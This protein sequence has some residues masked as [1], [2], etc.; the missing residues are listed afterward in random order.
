MLKYNATQW[1]LEAFTRIPDPKPLSL[2]SRLL[3]NAFKYNNT[4]VAKYLMIGTSTS[5]TKLDAISSIIQHG[6]TE[7]FCI[8][9]NVSG[10]ATAFI[11]PA[12]LLLPCIN[13]GNVDFV[14]LLLK[15]NCF[16][17]LQENVV[18]QETLELTSPR[19]I[20][21]DMLKMLHEEYNILYP[22]KNNVVWSE[23]LEY[24]IRHNL[25]DCVKYI[26]SNM[27]EFVDKRYLEGLLGFIVKHTNN[28]NVE[29]FESLC[30]TV[31]GPR[32]LLNHLYLL[33]FTQTSIHRGHFNIIKHL[34]T[35]LQHPSVRDINTSQSMTLICEYLGVPVPSPNSS[36][37]SNDVVATLTKGAIK[38]G[39]EAILAED[40]DLTVALLNEVE[41]IDADVWHKMS[42]K[43]GMFIT[44]PSH[45][46]LSPFNIVSLDGLL[47]SF[48]MPGC[49][50]TQDIILRFIDNCPST[51]YVGQHHS[52]DEE[53]INDNDE[54]IESL[55]LAAA[56]SQVVVRRMHS[57]FN[58][59]FTTDSLRDA[60]IS[61]DKETLS[62]IFD[63]VDEDALERWSSQI[64]DVLSALHQLL[65]TGT[66]EMIT[67]VLC[68]MKDIQYDGDVIISTLAS[69]HLEVVKFVFGMLSFEEIQANIELI[70][71]QIY[72]MDN[73]DA[74][75]WFGELFNGAGQTL[76]KATLR[77][78][79]MAT[80]GNAYRL[81]EL[82]FQSPDFNNMSKVLR[83]RT[84]NAIMYS[85]QSI[86]NTRIINH[87]Q[88]LIKLIQSN[89]KRDRDQHDVKLDVNVQASERLETA[90]HRVFMD[91]KMS[92]K[93]MDNVAVV[94]QSLGITSCVKGSRLLSMN[95]LEEYIKYGASQWFHQSYQVLDNI[96]PMHPNTHLLELAMLYPNTSILDTL[97]ADPRMVFMPSVDFLE[98][99]IDYHSLCD[100]PEW[101]RVLDQYIAITLQQP[102]QVVI[103]ESLLER[104]K[105]PS[106]IR[107]L[108]SLGCIIKPIT[109][110]SLGLKFENPWLTS[111]WALEMFTI[112]REN[113]LIDSHFQ[114][115]LV[116]RS[117]R[118][119][120]P[121]IIQYVLDHMNDEDQQGD[122]LYNNPINICTQPKCHPDIIDLV[123]PTLPPGWIDKCQ[124]QAMLRSVAYSGDTNKFIKL[125]NSEPP[126]PNSSY[127]V[128]GINSAIISMDLIDRLASHPN[129]NCKFDTIL[130]SAIRAGKRDIIDKFKNY[131]SGKSY[132]DAFQQA[133]AIG[134][135][136]TAKMIIHL[137]GFIDQSWNYRTMMI[138]R[139]SLVSSIA[140]GHLSEDD[141]VDLLDVMVSSS[142]IN[143]E[144]VIMLIDA[145]SKN[146]H[147]HVK[148]VINHFASSSSLR[149]LSVPIGDIQRP[150][151]SC[152]DRGDIESIVS[153]VDFAQLI[154][155]SSKPCQLIPMESISN[156]TILSFILDKGY[157]K[158]DDDSHLMEHLVDLVCQHG[159]ID[160]LRMIHQRCST[161]V[162]LRRYLFEDNEQQVSP[163]NNVGLIQSHF[164]HILDVVGLAALQHGH[165]NIIKMCNRIR[166]K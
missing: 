56:I 45:K 101:E 130:G 11:L 143:Q 91:Y 111:P 147:R 81:L 19:C 25:P 27:P 136:A 61:S 13:T 97:L 105:H 8:L 54:G 107:K 15:H 166:T 77:N 32:P 21:V 83:H 46:D 60:L 138:K 44:E 157:F 135:Y 50:L 116:M 58:I 99:F 134:D 95:S 118:L 94:H 31:L 145:A 59:E 37:N 125:L 6:N 43:M 38:N 139:D 122:K 124:F 22:S 72:C 127:I 129:V 140:S 9:F 14:R 65:A 49:T 4:I 66:L 108:L 153:L 16:D 67:Y 92:R 7:L 84:I 35:L 34:Y 158:L 142:F 141:L 36:S 152:I 112:L 70:I 80:S 90:V 121:S 155:R 79:L 163:F 164:V 17:N 114:R 5:Y 87:C 148:L 78:L 12:T 55:K 30:G 2:V 149:S 137:D 51:L 74:L 93:I 1:F 75:A 29:I 41:I 33:P 159:H 133:M 18:N 23:A 42:I 63:Q 165:I 82:Y 162:Q 28:G 69:R 144:D 47:E 100:R 119:N 150:I 132:I 156:P 86:G 113:K 102:D 68:E 98:K 123:L 89:R 71:T 131:P 57:H 146:S 39:V 73:I 26:I 104:I 10:S 76:P 96:P 48:S 106:F 120:I 151:R 103:R 126:S 88:S 110:Y 115:G 24:S 161:P 160:V 40:F 3:F 20:T 85:A 117:T 53:D 109:D 62:M 64:P 52:D 128:T 154:T